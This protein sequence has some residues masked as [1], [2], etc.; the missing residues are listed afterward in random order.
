MDL[1]H[2]NDKQKEVV[3]YKGNRLGVIAGPGSGKTR[4]FT[5]RI[6]YLV[7]EKDVPP[8]YIMATAFTNKSAEEIVERLVPMI[9][10]MNALKLRMGTFHSVSNGIYKQLITKHRVGYRQPTL[11]NRLEVWN[12]V[13]KLTKDYDFKNKDVKRIL[14]QISLWKNQCLTPE[15]I[16][17]KLSAEKQLTLTN[18]KPSTM[19]LAGDLFAYKEYQKYLKAK[20]KMDFDDM[21]LNLALALRNPKYQDDVARLRKRIK[22]I[23][24]DEC[25]PY[26]TYVKTDVG[27]IKI[28]SLNGM[29]ERGED[30]PKVLTF[31]NNKT[32]Y[33]NICHVFK[34][35]T[36]GLY[37]VKLGK[38]KIRATGNHLVKVYSYQHGFGYKKI[39]AL[40]EGDFCVSYREET[41]QFVNPI[42]SNTQLQ[43]IFGSIL[44]DGSLAKVSN[45]TYR[46]AF[47]HDL[48]TQGE[49]CLWKMEFF[50]CHTFIEKNQGYS[51]NLQQKGN[52]TTFCYNFG[53]DA[54]DTAIEKLDLLGL[55]VLWMD[56]GCSRGTLSINSFTE[57]QAKNL[58]KKI[59]E[60]IGVSGNLRISKGKY[61]YL[62]YNKDECST[63]QKK[64][65]DYW[66]PQ[67]KYKNIYAKEF[68]TPEKEERGEF[69]LVAVTSKKRIEHSEKNLYDLNVEDNH[70]YIICSSKYSKAG[71]VVHNCQDTNL[72]QYAILKGLMG[73]P[74]D[75]VNIFTFGDDGQCQPE[76]TMVH[77][78]GG[79]VVPIEKI[80]EGDE[81]ITY[82]KENASFVGRVRKGKKV[83]ATHYR[84]I[85]ENIYKIQIGDLSTKATKEHIWYA[86]FKDRSTRWNVVYL[87]Y[88]NGRF[89]VGW[90]QL[91]QQ[92]GSN[93]LQIRM[94]HEKAEKVWILGLYPNKKD[95]SLHEKIFATDYGLPLITFE[96]L[97]N[98]YLD[99]EGIDFIFSNLTQNNIRGKTL[100]KEHGLDFE[101]PFF[102]VKNKHSKF[103]SN[104]YKVRTC[105]LLPE[106]MALPIYKNRRA[107]SKDIW[108]EFEIELEPYEGRVYSLEVEKHHTY[109][110]DGIVT[111]NCIYGFR[112][113]D[114]SHL[115]RFNEQFNFKTIKLEQNYRSTSQI[116]EYSNNLI[117]NNKVQIPKTINTKNMRGEKANVFVCGDEEE[118]ALQVMDKIGELVSEG[119]N[120]RDIAILYRVNAQSRAIVDTFVSYDIPHKVYAKYSF[121]ERKEIRDI[122]AYLKIIHNPYNATREDFARIINKPSRYL[123]NA[124]IEAIANLMRWEGYDNFYEALTNYHKARGLKHFQ[125]DSIKRFIEDIESYHR[126]VFN[127][128]LTTAQIIN[129]IIYEVGYKEYLKKEGSE[130]EGDEDEMMNLEALFDGAERYDD[131]EKYF[132]FI[133]TIQEKNDSEK[134]HVHCMTVH[135]AKGKEFPVVFVIGMGNKI[136]PHGKSVAE[137]KIEDERRI[138]YVAI[139]RAEEYLYL[140]VID[141][142]FGKVKMTPSPFIEEMGIKLKRNVV[143]I[144][145][146]RENETSTDRHEQLNLQ[147]LPYIPPK[148]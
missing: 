90:C 99:R 6:A 60:L 93:H 47:N 35:K 66:H 142:R 144:N 145:E 84:E 19:M 75:N 85:D 51:D 86:K 100:L 137:G 76:G 121:Y 56:D 95:A 79:G 113:S 68:L 45:H 5:E 70:N 118:E 36:K 101:H 38:S 31:N 109:V 119:F 12:L 81:V 50:N 133:E 83:L 135:G 104:I 9:G 132:K 2:L 42:L 127:K 39:K 37:E 131:V 49:Y 102:N 61:F 21:L 46:L 139:T 147:R 40:S 105:N 16:E 117:Q 80:R 33:K 146:K 24:V 88:Q 28:G 25:V 69:G 18:V 30:L 67:L 73:E 87:M 138:A 55:A 29:Y 59:R 126:Y 130:A 52:S 14:K 106:I 17:K 96:P 91:F 116:V 26:N 22:Y 103:G 108:S 134:D 112:G 72:V 122:L 48:K 41:T 111:H 89:R 4:C 10:K 32:E 129:M 63:I 11:V 136:F 44:G 124:V 54:V 74:S 3:L 110:A 7:N 140:G 141:G 115:I 62:K 53:K 13:R 71:T 77:L 34:N 143:F 125:F 98:S 107:A 23:Q 120:F 8:Q 78:T 64:L 1:S 128:G 97:G 114:V 58:L 27:N 92:D 43:V 82:D 94:N 123:G 57:Q 65:K 15:G 20:G 148:N